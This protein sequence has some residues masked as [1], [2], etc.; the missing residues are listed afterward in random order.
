MVRVSESNPEQ[1]GTDLGAEDPGTAVNK[2]EQNMGNAPIVTV[3]G[4]EVTLTS[5][6]VVANDICFSIRP[7]EILGVVGESGSG[8]TTVGMTLLGYVRDGAHISGGSV[9]VD[10]IELMN[11]D[12]AKLRSLRGHKVSYVSQDPSAAF[13]PALRIRKQLLQFVQAHSTGEDGLN[14]TT[15]EINARIEEVFAEVNLP[16]ELEFQNRYPHQLSGGQLQRVAIALALLLKPPVLILDEPTTGLDVT[17]QDKILELVRD[18]CTR[19]QIAALYVTH[20]LAVVAD[21]ADSVMVMRYGQVVEHAPVKDIFCNPQQEYTRDLIAAAPDL[22]IDADTE[23]A[24]RSEINADAV[25]SVR[26][27]EARYGR[28]TVLTDINFDLERGECL[29]LVGESGSGKSTLSKCLIGLHDNYDGDVALDGD[30]IPHSANRR[31]LKTRRE[32]QY[33]FQ[34]PHTSLN[35][36]KTVAESIGM[37]HA[38]V[39]GNRRTRREETLDVLARVGLRED[40]ASMY[41]VQLSGG[42]RQRVSIARALIANPRVL[43]CDEVTSALDVIVQASI[44]ELLSKLQKEEQ[45]SLLFVTHN[46]AVVSELADRILVMQHGK[47]VEEG[48]ADQ[49]LHQPV[50]EY[51]K[52]LVGNTLSIQAVRDER[53]DGQIPA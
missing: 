2:L 29:A 14:V 20:D 31:A 32:M 30:L 15:A 13:N 44:L 8:K 16:T 27:L 38:A 23:I 18:L 33:I 25:L 53:W 4:L 47:I 46:L 7:G 45:L 49:V 9:I 36:R 1:S 10:G 39:G 50:H 17:S 35:P 41:P 51:T 48:A 37:V 42:E 24:E 5:G 52:Q 40:H 12:A 21:I 34:S 6:R 43:I 11:A 3:E 26:N 22:V 19:H 28:K